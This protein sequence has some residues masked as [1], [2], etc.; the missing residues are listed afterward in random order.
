MEKLKVTMEDIQRLKVFMDVID[1]KL[2]V[3]DASATLSSILLYFCIIILFKEKTNFL[4]SLH[5]KET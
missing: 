2:K 4:S 3:A 5:L 1:K